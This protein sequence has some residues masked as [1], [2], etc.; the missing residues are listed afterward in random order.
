MSD[1]LMS[2]VN[3]LWAFA[4]NLGDKTALRDEVEAAIMELRAERDRY[5]RE[6]EGRRDWTA[7]VMPNIKRTNLAHKNERYRLRRSNKRIKAAASRDSERRM[8]EL[9]YALNEIH[10][11]RETLSVSSAMGEERR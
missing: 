9:A 1:E 7:R 5:Q 6:A 4:E 8:L 2:K 11:L 3:S 10:D